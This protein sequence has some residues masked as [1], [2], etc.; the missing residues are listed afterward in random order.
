MKLE[1]KGQNH[2]GRIIWI[3]ADY[4]EESKPYLGFELEEW[5]IPRYQDLVETAEG[6]MGRKLSKKEAL[7]MAW[8][9]CGDADACQHIIGFIKESHDKK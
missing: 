4:Y 9:S 5:Q 7:T 8:L 1:Y 3:D 2:R 6:C